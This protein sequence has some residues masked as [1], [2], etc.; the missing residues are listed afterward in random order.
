MKRQ[1]SIFIMLINVEISTV[2][3]ILTFMSMINT[4]AES[5]KARKVYIFNIL[6]LK[7]SS[8]KLSMKSV[9][10]PRDLV[11]AVPSQIGDK[12]LVKV[13]TVQNSEIFTHA[14]SLQTSTTTKL[15]I[16]SEML[17]TWFSILRLTL[18]GI[19]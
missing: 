16:K 4:T 2:V 19:I 6:D 5:L 12:R 11:C 7:S 15:T 10:K 17:S 14:A 9:V 1:A 3:G 8:A 18:Y 13:K